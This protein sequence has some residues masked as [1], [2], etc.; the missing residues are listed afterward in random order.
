M[1]TMLTGP[2]RSAAPATSRRQRL[3]LLLL[4]GALPFSDFLQTGVFAF[5]AAPI[6]GEL[7]ASPEEFSL[8]AT[9]YAVTAIGMIFN[10][11]WLVE[12]MGWRWFMRCASFLFAAGAMVCATS[13][14]LASFTAGRLIT[15]MGCASFFTAGRVLV[16][17]IPPS[18]KRFTG[19]KFFASGI[20]WGG[21]CGPM[22]ASAALSVQDWRLAFS[23]QV[24]PAALIA[25][26]G[27]LSLPRL[28]PPA[29]T[30][31]DARGLVTLAG[32][33]A[34]VLFA[35]QRSAFDFYSERPSLYACVAIGLLA[36]VLAVWLVLRSELPAIRLHEMSQ[37]RY[38]VGL[39]AFGVSYA[40]LGGNN[41]AVP[42]LLLRGLNLPLEVIGRYV[43]VGGLG[44]VTVWILLARLVPRNPGPTRYYV[45]GFSLLAACGVL[46]G[47]LSETVDPE[48]HLLPALLCNGAFVIAV[49]STTAVQT[50]RDL[51][52]DETLFSHANQVKNVLAQFGVAAGMC[53]ATL[54]IQW[55]TTLHCVRVGEALGPSSLALQ[56]T[57]RILSLRY[58][59]THEPEAAARMA[60]AT[61]NGLL[62]QQSS[63]MAALDYFVAIAA[64]AGL[65]L[66]AVLAERVFR[67]LRRTGASSA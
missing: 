57:L 31:F 33:S 19:V 28:P 34:L 39:A 41:T 63:F 40:L 5:N 53:I 55:R 4:I 67:Y 47:R 16:N 48:A 29:H 2:A 7:G 59:A 27:E 1:P 22:L 61:V 12:Q 38:L 9:F 49:L 50:F 13:D 58:G 52:R 11:R 21:V 20:A 10:H 65:C 46:L 54:F 25:L 43:A 30:P 62:L 66:M 26:F 6:M 35:L 45:L 64:V 15:A 60:T 24:V 56:E 37:R 23:A 36:L 51:Q 42:L 3:S 18:P 32:G 17:L 8:V 44:G 14:T